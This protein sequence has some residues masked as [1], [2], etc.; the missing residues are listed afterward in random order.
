MMTYVMT[1][2]NS[3]QRERFAAEKYKNFVTFKILNFTLRF[4]TQGHPGVT[5][6]DSG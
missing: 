5:F 1:S 4:M 3:F 2:Q 6:G